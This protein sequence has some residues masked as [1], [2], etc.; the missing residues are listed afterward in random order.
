MEPRRGRDSTRHPACKAVARQRVP[1]PRRGRGAASK[2]ERSRI[3]PRLS[4]LHSRMTCQFIFGGHT[5]AQTG[6]PF[7]S[8]RSRTHSTATAWG[9]AV[10]DKGSTISFEPIADRGSFAR[11]NIEKLP[12]AP[13]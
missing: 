10:E 9:G 12:S 1:P 11:L 6:P 13:I 4:I 7:S 8:V 3:T 2:T 5:E